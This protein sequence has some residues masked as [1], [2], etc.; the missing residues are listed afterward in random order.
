MLRRNVHCLRMGWTATVLATFTVDGFV[1]H[2]YLAFGK[3]PFKELTSSAI[4]DFTL[5]LPT[6]SA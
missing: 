2:W 5:S 6:E 3:L 1:Q 4:R